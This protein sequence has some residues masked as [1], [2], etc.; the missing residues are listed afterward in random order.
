MRAKQLA[1]FLFTTSL[2]LS[3]FPYS[4]AVGS[5]DY[6]YFNGLYVGSYDYVRSLILDAKRERSL[7]LGSV[8]LSLPRSFSPLTSASVSARRTT[9]TNYIHPN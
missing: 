8:A 9:R 2:T 7:S 5:M 3:Y 4:E 1:D 6:F